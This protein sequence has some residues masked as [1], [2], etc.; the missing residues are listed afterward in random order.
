M[1]PFIRRRGP[2]ALI[3]ALSLVGLAGCGRSVQGT[4]TL[5][6]APVEEGVIEFTPKQGAGGAGTTGG[7]IVNGK[8]TL[9]SAK[10]PAPG[11]YRVEVH[12]RKKT[13]RRVPTPGD[14]D[15][16]MD[17]TV[18][19]VPANYNSVSTLTADVTSGG[20]TFDFPLKSR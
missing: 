4:V 11:S 1:T 12:W 8:Y 20:N 19:T 14:P 10:A 16:P 6:G 5:D 7:P 18:E 17:E 2:W 15:V 13:G 9:S 3:A